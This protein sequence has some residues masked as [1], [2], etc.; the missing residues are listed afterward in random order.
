MLDTF[1]EAAMDEGQTTKARVQFYTR[2]GCHLCDEAKA[3][4]ARAGCPHLF[5]LEE[6]DI[7]TDPRLAS[8]YGYDIPVVTI[9][10][11]HAF[12]HRLTAAD[13]RRE[14]DR[15]IVARR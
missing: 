7:D 11:A 2:A 8:L 1:T 14:I 3:E 13:F 4:I 6:I 10:G 15:A 12:K 9:D 5:D